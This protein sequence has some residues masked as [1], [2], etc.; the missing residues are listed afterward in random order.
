MFL[1][2]VELSG[3][4]DKRDERDRKGWGEGKNEGQEGE[5]RIR[6]TGEGEANEGIVLGLEV[7]GS[8]ELLRWT[9]KAIKAD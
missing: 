7:G 8:M 4:Q 6:G 9:K 5:R 2:M 3:V 1:G